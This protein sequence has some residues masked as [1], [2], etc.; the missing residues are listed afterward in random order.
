MSLIRT[1]YNSAHSQE[2]LERVLEA[3]QKVG[4]ALG[5]I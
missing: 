3:F 1:S 4:K 2:Q 5:V